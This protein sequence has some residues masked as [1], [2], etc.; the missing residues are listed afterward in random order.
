MRA[1]SKS[2]MCVWPLLFNANSMLKPV[3]GLLVLFK[4]FICTSEIKDGSLVVFVQ[5][6]CLFIAIKSKLVFSF[7]IQNN[8]FVVPIIRVEVH[9]LDSLSIL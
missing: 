4:L 2:I 9:L 5:L 6:Q 7:L 8:T 1:K 3:K